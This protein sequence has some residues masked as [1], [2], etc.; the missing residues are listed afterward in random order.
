MKTQTI[1]RKG[2]SKQEPYGVVTEP[3]TVR[4]ER[5]LPGPITR[6]WAYLV[7][8]D[9]RGKWLA[10]G[11]MDQRVGGEVELRFNHADLSCEKTPP[12]EFKQSQCDSRRLSH[13][14]R[15]DAPRLLSYTWSE[16]SD[17]PS[18]VTFE[19]AP[20]GDDVQLTVTHR[21]LDRPTM[22]MVS[23]GWHTHLGILTDTLH[24]EE[25]RPFWSTF[26]RLKGEYA[27]RLAAN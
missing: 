15:L 22:L 1:E 11:A 14:T 13:I 6:V 21:K 4:I 27:T 17:A 3:G 10:S 19:L 9:K 7:E 12:D 5:V 16:D 20:H 18:E 23:A 8:S 25:P 26:M 24:G 2:A